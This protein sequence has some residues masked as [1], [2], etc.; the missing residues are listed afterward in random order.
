M[1][2]SLRDNL[3]GTAAVIVVG[4]MVVPLVLF[5]VDSIFVDSGPDREVVEVD[6]EAITETELQR[7]ILLRQGQMRAQFGDDLP[8]QFTSAENLREPVL[9]SL[10]KRRLLARAARKG[11]MTVSDQHINELLVTAPE[12][13][14]EGR[15]DPDLF[16]QRVYN[17][18]YSP[19]T[20]RQRL[21]E[22][23]ILN[24]KVSG[25]TESGFITEGE[26]ESTAALSLQE[27]DFYYLTVP[28]APLEAEIDVEEEVARAY[29]ED[30][31]DEYRN[32]EQV[33]IE[34][35]EVRLDEIAARIDIP[36]QQL[37]DQYEQEVAA[38]NSEIERHAAHILIEPRNDGSE[39]ALLQ[40]IRER[41][42]AGEN[43]TD[44]AEEYS[45]DF[46]TRSI[47]GELGFTTGD[48]F[49][50]PFEEALANL[51]TGE[52][53]EPVRTDAG[54][55]LIKL[56]DIRGAEPPTFEQDRNRIA[57]ILKNAEAQNRFVELI[58]DLEDET[59]TSQD[60]AESAE[61][62][63][64]QR[65]VSGPFSRSGGFGIASNP[66]VVDAAFSEDVLIE[67]N[68]SELLELGPDHAMVLRVTN[69][70]EP[71]NLSFEEVKTEVERT[72]KRE[73]AVE[74]VTEIGKQLEAEV[75]AGKT[76]EEV[77]KANDYQWQVSLN[78][79]RTEPQVRR[80]ILTRVFAL[81]RPADEAL[82]SGF[83]TNTGDYV[84]VNLTEVTDGDYHG[85][86][87]SEKANLRQ[88]LAGMASDSAYAAYEA[89]LEESAKIKRL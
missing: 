67:G 29:Y 53:S 23:L 61:I 75:A 63:G 76:I 31:K 89:Q 48:T 4:L 27:R 80:D 39:Q 47:G 79:Q 35:L 84:V 28:L 33:S 42:A 32:P 77:A 81:P 15:F 12:F 72:L 37:R 2:Q 24:Q 43:F 18:G 74:R 55:H 52:V 45:E 59:Y 60:L 5:G 62:L 70:E 50:A 17:V 14:I 78:T 6:G 36:E 83:T 16:R 20:Y 49:P 86:S 41:L 11:G 26:L 51:E 54:F 22:D 87:E 58:Q 25:L 8:A 3:K 66:T 19:I 30:H 46:G 21:A 68:T 34:Y 82:V 1:L 44:L 9:D 38:F 7:A 65:R 13:Q 88:R 56:L 57:T 69:H 71:R 73:M 64:L 10:I 40:E 85:M